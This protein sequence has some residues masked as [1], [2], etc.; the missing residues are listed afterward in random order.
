MHCTTSVDLSAVSSEQKQEDEKRLN[1]AD[2]ADSTAQLESCGAQ[3]NQENG[4]RNRG[5][6]RRRMGGGMSEGDMED[7]LARG[8]GRTS[9]GGEG[10]I[11]EEE[12]K[13]RTFGDRL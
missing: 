8:R 6:D 5:R 4:G 12:G 9:R 10:R 13:W 11:I 1:T 7:K 3:F 2:H